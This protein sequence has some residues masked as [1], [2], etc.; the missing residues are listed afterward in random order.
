[1][2]A[3]TRA[4]EVADCSPKVVRSLCLSCIAG[5]ALITVL[6]VGW[7]G[8]CWWQGLGVVAAAECGA[9]GVVLH[10]LVGCCGLL[11][12]TGLQWR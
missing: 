6:Q 4:G 11:L 9:A 12:V 2:R 1:M 5:P 3:P 10:L 8:G 7:G